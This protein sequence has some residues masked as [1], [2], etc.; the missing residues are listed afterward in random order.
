MTHNQKC[1]AVENAISEIRLHDEIN[2]KLIEKICDKYGVT[3]KHI[4]TVMQIK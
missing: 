1:T 2:D 3:V 4:K